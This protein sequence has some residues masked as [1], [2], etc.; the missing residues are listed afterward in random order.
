MKATSLEFATAP[1]REE[2]A[3]PSDARRRQPNARRRRPDKRRRGGDAD[4][5]SSFLILG[6]VIS[7]KS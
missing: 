1:V 3:K 6:R 2:K 5:S 7:L 4:R